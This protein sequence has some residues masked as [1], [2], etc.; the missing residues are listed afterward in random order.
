MEE[1]KPSELASF[2]TEAGLPHEVALDSAKHINETMKQSILRL[3]RSAVHVGREWQPGL[4]AASS[5]GLVFWGRQDEACPVRFAYDLGRDA[6]AS[7]VVTLNAGHWVIVQ[8]PAEIA[9]ALEAHWAAPR[10]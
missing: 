10:L 4:R 3:Y 6:A 9:Q 1:L 5:P 7:Q 8:R 2:M